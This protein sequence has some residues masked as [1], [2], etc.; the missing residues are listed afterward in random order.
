MNGR[1]NAIYEMPAR[2]ASPAPSALDRFLQRGAP[3]R[4]RTALHK[5]SE[6]NALELLKE[7]HDRIKPGA[8]CRQPPDG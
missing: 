5:G 8:R 3:D 2:Y 4:Q 7:D 1:L 6:M